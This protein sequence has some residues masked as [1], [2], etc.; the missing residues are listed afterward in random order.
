MTNSGEHDDGRPVLRDPATL[1]TT[2]KESR[3]AQ[4]Q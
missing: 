4:L 2:Q 1:I 3:R